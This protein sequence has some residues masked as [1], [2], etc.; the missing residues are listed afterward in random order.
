MWTQIMANDLRER[1]FQIG[2]VCVDENQGMRYAV[3]NVPCLFDT[4]RWPEKSVRK[5]SAGRYPLIVRIMYI[6]LNYYC[7]RGIDPMC[8]GPMRFP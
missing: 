6:M 5:P 3:S 2:T 4:P 1:T 7:T 8:V